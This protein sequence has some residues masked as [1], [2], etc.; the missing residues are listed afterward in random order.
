MNLD[1]FLKE[2]PVKAISHVLNVSNNQ[3]DAKKLEYFDYE[4]PCCHVEL[5]RL[6]ALNFC[7]NCGQRLIWTSK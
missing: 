2:K 4:C 7:G 1:R 3:N 6:H 5:M